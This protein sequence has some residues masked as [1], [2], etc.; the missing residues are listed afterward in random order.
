MLGRQHL[1][2]IAPDRRA[3]MGRR[4]QADHL[5]PEADRPVVALGG[6]VVEADENRHGTP[7][8][9]PEAISA[10]VEVGGQEDS[11]RGCF[12]QI[13]EAISNFAYASRGPRGSRASDHFSIGFRYARCGGAA[14]LPPVFGGTYKPLI[15]S[16]FLGVFRFAKTRS[17]GTRITPIQPSEKIL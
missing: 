3:A 2:G 4:A 5:R 9:R 16:C 7:C 15:E 1:E 8:C 10:R 6:D 11:R 14:F 13:A 12:T 17:I